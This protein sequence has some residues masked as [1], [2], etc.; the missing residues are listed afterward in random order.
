MVLQHLTH[1]VE[2]RVVLA[3]DSFFVSPLG[4]G[5]LACEPA[6]EKVWPFCGHLAQTPMFATMR[7]ASLS[8]LTYVTKMTLCHEAVRCQEF[9]AWG[10]GS[11]VASSRKTSPKFWST[12]L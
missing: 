1:H 4:T 6:C 10:L 2:Q 7:A 5:W 9:L 12:R 8:E 3:P 11:A